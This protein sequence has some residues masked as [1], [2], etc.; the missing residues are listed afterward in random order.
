MDMIRHRHEH[1]LQEFPICPPIC[2]VDGLGHGELAGSVDANE[3]RKL[4]LGRLNLCDINME[5]PD[6]VT[7]EPLPPR[8]V[9]F[10]IRQ[11]RN[12]MPLQAPVQR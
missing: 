8:L 5:K 10:D 12:S 7:L 4:S 3:E 9:S 6:R 2:L 1:V 11:A